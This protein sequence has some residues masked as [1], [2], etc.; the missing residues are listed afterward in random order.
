M[1]LKPRVLL[2]DGDPPRREAL[3]AALSDGGFAVTPAPPATALTILRGR[4]RGAL[5]MDAVVISVCRE[6]GSLAER[7][8]ALPGGSTVALVGLAGA[9]ASL[10]EELDE[11]VF[12]EVLFR[13]VT[14]TQLRSCLRRLLTDP[15][16]RSSRLHRLSQR[17]ALR[18][19]Q[20][21]ALVGAARTVTATTDLRETVAE[22]LARYRAA[23]LFDLCAVFLRRDA[24][25]F[26]LLTG[27]GTTLDELEGGL[28]RALPLLESV[29]PTKPLTRL[30]TPHL[31]ALG[32]SSGWLAPLL[33][34][35]ELVGIA[36]LGSAATGNPRYGEDF[37][38]AVRAQLT[39]A[40]AL[41]LAMSRLAASE[42]RFRRIAD[43]IPEGLIAA[44]PDGRISFANRRAVQ[45]LGDAT[46]PL[47][48]RL[49]SDVLPLEHQ[50]DAVVELPA[51][52]GY[53][54]LEAVVRHFRDRVGR[55][56]ATV[57]LKDVTDE[58]KVRARLEAQAQRDPLTGLA[59]R[60]HFLSEA[61]R[62]LD[63]VAS[64]GGCAGLF[65]LDLDHFKAVNDRLGHAAGDRLL[66]II[67]EGLRA[68]LRASDLVGRI[69]GDEFVVLAPLRAM[70]DALELGET[71]RGI[72][73]DAGRVSGAEEI[74]VSVG[75]ACYPEHGDDLEALIEQADRAM[76]AAKRAGR[77]RSSLPPGR[78]DARRGIQFPTSR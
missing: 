21:A 25:G 70:E 13:P 62:R 38:E 45:L 57:L 37:V 29:D 22:S 19:A 1:T 17:Y 43:A 72:V 60:R 58:R 47:E 77:G 31:E 66:A 2:V 76:Y 4:D 69:G 46:G 15:E 52:D 41:G 33:V 61:N 14:P 28:V 35:D 78:A 56:H 27:T 64:R 12:D 39:L 32:L 8:R 49:L 68:R 20:L 26:A 6:G 73:R 63:G 75:V 55:R 24:G 53:G 11:A 5:P 74:D 71:L 42:D 65:F 3:A 16:A 36:L 44:R 9:A 48:G 34:D 59:N 67:A 18:S 50:S 23:E 40:A 10:R 30:S 51:P 54:Q 7:V